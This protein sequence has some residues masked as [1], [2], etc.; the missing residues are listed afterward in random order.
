MFMKYELNKKIMKIIHT[1]SASPLLQSIY[2]IF[3]D[4]YDACATDTH[5]R[6]QA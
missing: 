1:H 4:I 3:Y 6:A 2:A 5:K